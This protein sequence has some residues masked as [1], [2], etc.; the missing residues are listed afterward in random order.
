M[1][2]AHKVRPSE[3][4]APCFF[5]HE[6][7]TATLVPQSNF[8]KPLGTTGLPVLLWAVLREPKRRKDVDPTL[9]PLPALRRKELRPEA[10]HLRCSGS[11][12]FTV[13]KSPG[14]R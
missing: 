1:E 12:A 14:P 7:P 11:M 2:E 10:L 13:L 5:P 3:F 8:P 4:S 9:H 6:K